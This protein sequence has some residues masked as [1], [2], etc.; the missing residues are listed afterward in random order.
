M[1]GDIYDPGEKYLISSDGKHERGTV[2]HAGR[3][4]NSFDDF[5]W[6]RIIPDFLEYSQL[7]G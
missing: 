2:C 1:F 3:V 5:L 7:H 6:V 4:S